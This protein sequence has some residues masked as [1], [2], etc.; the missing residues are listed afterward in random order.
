MMLYEKNEYYKLIFSK[1]I[2]NNII[3]YLILI[4]K[5]D[6][7]LEIIFKIFFLFYQFDYPF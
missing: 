5:Y 6:S 2:I 7:T 3:I 1:F 4:K